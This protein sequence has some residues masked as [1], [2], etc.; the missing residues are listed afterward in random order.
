MIVY[1]A[2]NKINGHSYIG[3]TT[4]SLEKR[5]K[6]H[7]ATFKPR[8]RKFQLALHK[9]GFNN[10]EWKTVAEA[11]TVDELKLLEISYIEILKPEYNLTVGGDGNVLPTEETRK[12]ISKTLMGHVSP[13][14]GKNFVQ[15]AETKLK[16]SL[17]WKEK[18]NEEGFREKKSRSM[19]GKNKG[20]RCS[21]EQKKKIS[22]TLKGNIPWNKGKKFGPQSSITKQKRSASMKIAWEKRKLIHK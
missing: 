6:G 7:Q 11:K 2:I 13:N 14:R 12:K 15:S 8:R 19:I 1:Q 16:K 10:F 21:E 3:M 17:F 18:Y 5:I 4:C 20:K 9:Y 22:E